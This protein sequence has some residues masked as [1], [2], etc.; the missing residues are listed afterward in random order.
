MIKVTLATF[1]KSGGPGRVNRS[2]AS[3]LRELGAEVEE[4]YQIDKSLREN[5]SQAPKEAFLASL[6]DTLVKSIG[7]DKP[8]SLFRDIGESRRKLEDPQSLIIGWRNGFINLQTITRFADIPTIMRLPDMNAF[9]GVCHYSGPCRAFETDCSGCPAVKN[10]FQKR[11]S[12][13]LD[14]KNR[15]YDS[16]KR[17]LFVAPSEWMAGLAKRSAILAGREIVVIPNPVEDEFFSCWR[18]QERY[19]KPTFTFAASQVED[20]VKGFDQIADRLHRLAVEKKLMIRVIG[21]A[22]RAYIRRFPCFTFLGRVGTTELAQEF[23]RTWCV[24][25]PSVEEAYGNVVAEALASGTPV[26]AM[27][28]GGLPEILSQVDDRWTFQHHDDLISSLEAIQQP[29]SREISENISSRMN[30]FSRLQTSKAYLSQLLRL[31]GEKYDQ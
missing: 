6:D 30:P 7:N 28:S 3:G 19:D 11:V 23:G 31:A 17:L 4:V 29:P 16:L 8:I 22:S 27:N 2:L 5:F 13:N 15:A 26:R 14:K 25:V 18:L 21:H 24:F 20:P 12:L 1:S 10:L 9:T